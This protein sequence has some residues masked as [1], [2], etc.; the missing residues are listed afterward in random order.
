MMIFKGRLT[1][2]EAEFL[3]R[4]IHSRTTMRIHTGAFI[5]VATVV[6]VA[7]FANNGFDVRAVEILAKAYTIL[8]ALWTAFRFILIFRIHIAARA[9]TE[10]RELRLDA[11]S[12]TLLRPDGI[13]S[14]F[15]VSKL[16]F[17][18]VKRGISAYL[19]R[20]PVFLLPYRV[21]S[22]QDLASL[23]K[24]FF[25]PKYSEQKLTL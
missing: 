4:E 16:K 18:K 9:Q 12:V 6:G 25:A 7:T 14:T 10:D 17:R 3:L 19:G 21:L 23:D 1:K 5:G 22:K 13:V 20:V 24:M 11:E 2:A 15:P 8:F